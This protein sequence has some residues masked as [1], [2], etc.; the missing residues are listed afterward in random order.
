[1]ARRW[2][3]SRRTVSIRA[4]C[5]ST[6]TGGDGADHQQPE[7][8]GRKTITSTKHPPFTSSSAAYRDAARMER[9]WSKSRRTVSIRTACYSTRTGGDGADHQQPEQARWK[10][11]TSTKNPPFTSS[12][13]AYRDAARM[14]RRWST[15]NR[16]VSIRAARD[17]T[18]TGGLIINNPNRPGGKRSL[19][20]NTHRSRRVAKRI[21]TPHGWHGDGASQGARSRYELR[22]TRPERG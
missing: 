11:I 22:A 18:R 7:Q 8:A 10:A 13:A 12:S 17:S 2:S 1:M 21:E 5:D 15:S 9:R 19:Q 3:K 20:Q 4:A 14:E 6:R 16:M